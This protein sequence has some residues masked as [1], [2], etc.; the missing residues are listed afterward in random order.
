MLFPFIILPCDDAERLVAARPDFDGLRM[1]SDAVFCGPWI[2]C[3]V[4]NIHVLEHG[5]IRIFFALK[6][7]KRR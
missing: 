7:R 6:I 1:A 2:T 4:E 3:S 5:F